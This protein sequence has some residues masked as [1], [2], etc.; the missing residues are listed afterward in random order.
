MDFEQSVAQLEHI[1]GHELKGMQS[2]RIAYAL[3]EDVASF[4]RQKD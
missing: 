2:S 3:A 1:L 4:Y